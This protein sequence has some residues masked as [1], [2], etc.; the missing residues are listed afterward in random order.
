MRKRIITIICISLVAIALTSSLFLDNLFGSKISN[1]ITVITAVIGAGALFVQ[2]KKDKKINEANFI[3]NFSIHFYQ[4]YNCK[5]IMNELEK[6]RQDK[7]YKLDIDKWYT[8]IV[9]YLEWCESLSSMINNKVLSIEKIDDMMSY[10]FFLITN[11]KQI[12]DYELSEFRDFYRGIFKA[13]KEWSDYKKKKNLP[14]I[15]EETE[16]CKVKDYYQFTKKI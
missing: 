13:Y 4:I 12:Q 11:N 6:C 16:L 8:D 5:N 14:I 1:I 2:F 15:M 9:A 10:R 3:M 7:N